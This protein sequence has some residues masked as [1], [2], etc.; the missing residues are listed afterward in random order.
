MVAEKG[1][2]RRKMFVF[3]FTVKIYLEKYT[4][5]QKKRKSLGQ[6][7]STPQNIKMGYAVENQYTLLTLW[8]LKSVSTPRQFITT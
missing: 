6:Y 2:D 1:S 4:Q 5:Q 3:H 8:C 7:I